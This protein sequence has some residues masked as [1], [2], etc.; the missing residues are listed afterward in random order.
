MER[1][2]HIALLCLHGVGQKRPSMTRA[3]S[4]LK[5]K[6]EMEAVIREAYSP[7]P[8]LYAS[9]LKTVQSSDPDVTIDVRQDQNLKDFENK[10]LLQGESSSKESF[11]SSLGNSR[12]VE[13]TSLTPR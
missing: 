13:L 6:V 3:V 10:P 7:R 12:F 1:V 5:G 11:P 9:I 4:L 2:I 8:Q